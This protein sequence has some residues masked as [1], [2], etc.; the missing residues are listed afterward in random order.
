[1]IS[2]GRGE[3]IKDVGGFGH[4]K[5]LDDGSQP[6][7]CSQEQVAP[8]TFLTPRPP[9]TPPSRRRGPAPVVAEEVRKGSSMSV[10]VVKRQK[11]TVT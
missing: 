1:M 4:A 11:R 9:E 3:Y 6:L 2:R 10:L 5:T 7:V 8:P